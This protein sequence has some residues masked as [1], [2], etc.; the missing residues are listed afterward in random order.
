MTMCTNTQVRYVSLQDIILGLP[1]TAQH[2]TQ[3]K[4]TDFE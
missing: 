2:R 1:N 3:Y 4:S